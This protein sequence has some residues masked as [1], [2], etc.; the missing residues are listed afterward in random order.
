MHT[1]PVPGYCT[2][3]RDPFLGTLSQVKGIDSDN[4]QAES[5]AF[6]AQAMLYHLDIS[7]IWMAYRVDKCAFPL[8]AL[9][10]YFCLFSVFLSMHL[11]LLFP[12][13]PLPAN[14]VSIAGFMQDVFQSIKCSNMFIT[15]G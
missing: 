12:P 15:P 14:K 9:G 4:Q 8:S 6:L 13:F 11:C 10:V 7:V 5:S 2:I 3:Y 1:F